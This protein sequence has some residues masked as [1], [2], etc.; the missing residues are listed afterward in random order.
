MLKNKASDLCHV[1]TNLIKDYLI[2]QQN[3]S[4]DYSSIRDDQQYWSI[5]ALQQTQI[6]TLASQILALFMLQS[7]TGRLY[8]TI[9]LHIKADIEFDWIHC[10]T[11]SKNPLLIYQVIKQVLLQCTYRIKEYQN[12]SIYEFYFNYINKII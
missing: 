6:V 12:Y 5:A 9:K 2:T 8:S 4:T 3:Q 10:I 7:H 11:L 1:T